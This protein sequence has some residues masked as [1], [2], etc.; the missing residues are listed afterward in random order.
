MAA[1]TPSTAKLKLLHTRPTVQNAPSTED[2][3]RTALEDIDF[4][5]DLGKLAA[6]AYLSEAP[7]QAAPPATG[8]SFTEQPI[9]LP[10]PRPWT[11]RQRDQ[12]AVEYGGH[13]WPTVVQQAA[14]PMALA[15]GA[16]LLCLVSGHLL[17]R[18]RHRRP[19]V[20]AIPAISI[21]TT[22]RA[23]AEKPSQMMGHARYAEAQPH[24]LVEVRGFFRRE[25]LRPSAAQALQ[26]MQQAADADGVRLVVVSG[27]RSVEVQ[28]ELFFESKAERLQTAAERSEVL[29]PPGF[30]EHHTGYAVDLGDESIGQTGLTVDFEHSRAFEWL[31]Q[32]AAGHHFHLSFPRGGFVAFEPWHWR[33]EGD[34]HSLGVFY[35][36]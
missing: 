17:F 20:A 2:A 23:A 5:G 36:R 24:E 22:L 34:A 1:H 13:G 4:T 7:A 33:F 9:L 3:T 16:L 29:A 21:P 30:S 26:Q 19:V 18:S 12:A 35:G 32:H 31:Q 15:A 10:P 8:N 6:A 11:P 27:F 28:S 14:R 25:Q